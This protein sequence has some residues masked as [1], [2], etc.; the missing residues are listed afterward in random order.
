MM[1]FM[2][3]DHGDT[4]SGMFPI[5]VTTLVIAIIIIAFTS[6]MSG[7]NKKFEV[8]QIERKYILKMEAT[9]YLTTDMYNDLNKELAAAGMTVDSISTYG[10]NIGSTQKKPISINTANAD[11]QYG[12]TICLECKGK[13]NLIN[14]SIGAD[15]ASGGT[16][17]FFNLMAK[18][19]KISVDDVKSTT[20]K[21]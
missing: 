5:V 7:I 9:G 14:Y 2:K 19:I 18:K 13:I 3:K 11:L 20:L 1:K 16:G 6:W 8:N 10:Y 21:N 17:G 4:V 12:A 15:G